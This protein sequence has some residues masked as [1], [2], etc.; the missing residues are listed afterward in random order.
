M[1]FIPDTPDCLE[2][3]WS[4]GIRLQLLTQVAHVHGDGTGI[5]RIVVLPDVGEY[6]LARED[7]AG[8]PGQVPE[9]IELFRGQVQWVLA[10]PY[11]ATRRIDAQGAEGQARVSRR[12]LSPA[13]DR[14]DPCH[15]FRGAEGL[16]NV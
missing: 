13:K 11:R 10:K 3:A 7:L 1:E 14:L 8:M 16:A 5:A 4:A 15:Q 12:G 6:L 2:E 9:Q